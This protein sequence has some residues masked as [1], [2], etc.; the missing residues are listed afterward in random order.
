MGWPELVGV[1]R[2]SGEGRAKRRLGDCRQS[3]ALE[4]C[5][6]PALAAIVTGDSLSVYIRT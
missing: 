2:R 3:M 5:N 6:P 4:V 1:A